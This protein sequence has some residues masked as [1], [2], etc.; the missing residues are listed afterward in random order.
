M[1]PMIC[2]LVGGAAFA[3]RRGLRE[4]AVWQAARKAA[5]EKAG[6]KGGEAA[7]GMPGDF[8]ETLRQWTEKAGNLGSYWKA[9]SRDLRGF[10]NPMTQAE[11]YQILRLNAAASREKILQT[12]KQLMLK[13]HPDNGGSTYMATKVNEAKEK[14]LKGGR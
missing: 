13:N 5:A 12:H 9:F 1:W 6:E 11:A 10:E 7:K 4:A 8:S 2:L 14:L 3:A